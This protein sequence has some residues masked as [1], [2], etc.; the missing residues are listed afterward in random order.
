MLKTVINCHVRNRGLQNQTEKVPCIVL[1]NYLHTLCLIFSRFLLL[2]IYIINI[3]YWHVLFITQEKLRKSQC[4][5]STFKC[6]GST[7]AVL[8]AT[9]NYKNFIFYFFFSH[10]FSYLPEDYTTQWCLL[11]SYEITTLFQLWRSYF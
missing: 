3:R 6:W 10:K 7:E 4:T 9:K 11:R 5:T 2:F 1:L 8:L